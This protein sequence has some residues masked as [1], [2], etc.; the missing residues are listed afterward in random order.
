MSTIWPIPFSLLTTIGYGG[1]SGY[2]SAR[3]FYVCYFH[4]SHFFFPVPSVFHVFIK[5][6][7][8]F[9]NNIFLIWIQSSLVISSLSPTFLFAYNISESPFVSR[10]TRRYTDLSSFSAYPNNYP[11]HVTDY[12]YFPIFQHFY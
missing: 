2:Q 6:C 5:C 10:L 9:V 1:L 11:S 4:D 3:V 12:R 8:Y 7:K